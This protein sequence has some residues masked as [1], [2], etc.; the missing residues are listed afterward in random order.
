MHLS[1]FKRPLFVF[2]V[3]YIIF[4]AI[5]KDNLLEK[6][7]N[8]S[9][10]TPA[11]KAEIV[12]LVGEFPRK[13][14]K[15]TLFLKV[16][17]INGVPCKGRA[18]A[19]TDKKLNLRWMSE[20]AIKGDIS[21]VQTAG[22]IG[23][24]G[25]REYLFSKGIKTEINIFEI[26]E[27]KKPPFFA[28]IVNKLRE[29][30]LQTF[31]ENFSHEQAVI[32][33]GITL[34][35]TAELSDDLKKAFRDSGAMHLLVASGSNVGFVTC[36]VYILTSLFGINRKR[37]AFAALVAAGLYTLCAGADPPLL[38]AYIMAVFATTGF[39]LQREAGVFQGLLVS[40][41]LILIISPI[42]LFYAGFQMSF[43][44][45]LGILAAVSNYKV[46]NKLPFYVRFILVTFIVS[47]GATLAIYP[48]FALCFNRLSLISVFANIF[49]VPFSGILMTLG[50]LLSLVSFG[51]LLVFIVYPAKFLL[52]LFIFLVKFF[53]GFPFAAVQV[54]SFG[55]PV[56]FAY[57][58][59]ALA[60]FYLPNKVARKKILPVSFVLSVSLLILDLLFL[61]RSSVYLFS[62]K[63]AKSVLIKI[64]NS[65]TILVDAGINGGVLAKAVMA[66]GSL[67]VDNI[68]LTS[69]DYGSFSGLR[70]LAEIIKIKSVY[71]P[72][73]EFKPKLIRDIEYLKSKGVKVTR[74]WEGETIRHKKWKSVSRWGLLASKNGNF[75]RMS[76]Y[77]GFA[78]MDTMSYVFTFPEITLEVGANSYFVNI[79]K[80]KGIKGDKFNIISRQGYTTAI[81]FTESSLNVE[82]I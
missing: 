34:G 78:D 23:N 38:R 16:I 71:L 40:C 56:V 75:W 57:Y 10:F 36:I 1:Y 8:L 9:L 76:G 24:T 73:G 58:S 55:L 11:E 62:T 52:W 65:E 59:L 22:I 68:F 70:E 81:N 47:A 82:K 49:L 43:L 63:Y 39:V 48:V 60:I 2:L 21:P 7:D 61:S 18:V 27:S 20:V 32:L 64:K 50:F 51:R 31:A 26:K 15:T 42:T 28:L 66:T 69:S 53:A 45:T 13:Y 67:K 37:S 80:H 41:I 44:A 72:Y 33:G 74:L 25:G 5:R 14:E 17:S 12:A 35:E 77:S 3:L 79:L 29:H 54:A 4:V 19:Y 46:P 6:S 30:T